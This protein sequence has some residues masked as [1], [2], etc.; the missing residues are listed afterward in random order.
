MIYSEQGLL[1]VPG[2]AAAIFLFT[3]MLYNQSC[4]TRMKINENLWR[5]NEQKQARHPIGYR[6]LTWLMLTDM[7][8]IALLPWKPKEDDGYQ[9]SVTGWVSRRGFAN[10]FPL[11]AAE[12][13]RI[14]AYVEDFCQFVIQVGR[15]SN[16]STQ[17]RMRLLP[18]RH[19]INP[20]YYR[21]YT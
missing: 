15:G 2:Y 8:L 5:L 17:R 13:G 10:G 21:W 1:A 14:T 12:K 4:I 18:R 3:M 9:I 6:V 7:E 16:S 11:E 20:S 19:A